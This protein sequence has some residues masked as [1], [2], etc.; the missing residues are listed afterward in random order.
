MGPSGLTVTQFSGLE[1]G[2]LLAFAGGGGALARAT[3]VIRS[4]D[5][6]QRRWL[7]QERAWWIA[8]D[9]I[10]LLARRIPEIGEALDRWIERPIT[11]EEVLRWER[12]QTAPRPARPIYVPADVADAYAS[13]GLAPGAPA[14][15]VSTARRTLARRHHPDAGGQHRVMA[16]INGAAD[17]VMAW[18]ARHPS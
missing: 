5:P 14:A 3:R 18:L 6:W 16:A 15:A 12:L 7:M 8:D 11:I 10:S 1:D 17:T 2:Y 13:L 9:A 4:L